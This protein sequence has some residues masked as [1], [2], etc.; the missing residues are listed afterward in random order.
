MADMGP[1]RQRGGTWLYP[2]IGVVLEMVGLEEI[3]GYPDKTYHP[4]DVWGPCPPSAVP[5]GGETPRQYVSQTS[6]GWYMVVS[7][8]WCGSENGRTGGDRG[9]YCPP[10]EH[11]CTIYCDSSYHGFVS[12]GGVE[13]GNSPIQAMLG[14][15]CLG[16][17]GDKG[18][19]FR[20]GG[21]V[22]V[23]VKNNHREG[24]VG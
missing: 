21:G 12:G 9:I 24:I 6:K 14:A 5:P 19:A 20:S 10:P 2:P 3:G 15:S 23:Q 11:G 18:G 4:F 7:T 1:K 8:H 17:P 22:G 16:Y 13:S